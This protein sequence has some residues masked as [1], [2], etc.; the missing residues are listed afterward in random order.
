MTIDIIIPE[1]GEGVTEATIVAWHKIVGDSVIEG[2]LIVE[3]MTDKV[4]I[5]IDSI[6]AGTLLEILHEADEE[7]RIGTII[8][9]LGDGDTTTGEKQ[10]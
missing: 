9:R 4:N 3:I 2:E 8:A 1:I 7:V 10:K 6:G 5:E